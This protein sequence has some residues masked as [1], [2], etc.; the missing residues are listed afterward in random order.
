MIKPEQIKRIENAREV[1]IRELVYT[2]VDAMIVEEAQE[3][4]GVKHSLS[5][6]FNW[7][8]FGKYSESD[9]AYRLSIL[10]FNIEDIIKSYLDEFVAQRDIYESSFY[11]EDGEFILEYKV[12][13]WD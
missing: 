12:A 8:S 6:P 4:N 7:K 5:I 3:Y 9:T 11:S 2:T 10:E 13:R 1:V